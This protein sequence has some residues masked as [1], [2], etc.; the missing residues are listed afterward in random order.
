MAWDSKVTPEEARQ[1]AEDD[2][3]CHAGPEPDPSEHRRQSRGLRGAARV[4]ARS[5]VDWH[6]L[7]ITAMERCMGGAKPEEIE[8]EAYRQGG[9]VQGRGDDDAEVLVEEGRII[10]FAREGRGT[11]RPLGARPQAG[12]HDIAI[13]SSE[14]QAVSTPDQLAGVQSDRPLPPTVRG[15]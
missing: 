8:P 9:A 5:V 14:Q 3:G 13:L 12:E 4:R 2:H 11:M 1:V 7:A 15:K 6:E 10:A